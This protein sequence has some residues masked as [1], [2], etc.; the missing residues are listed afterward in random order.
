M[1]LVL[2][3]LGTA[4]SRPTLERAVPSVAVMRDGDTVLVDCGEGTQRQMLRYG[5][6]FA[7]DDV[8]FTHFHTDHFL[9]IIGLLRTLGL[10]GRTDALRL[11][12]PKGAAKWIKRAEDVGMDRL[13]FRLDVTEVQP[14][15]AIARKG[16]AWRAFAQEHRGTPCVGWALVEDTRLGRFDPD[17]ARTMGIPEG[18]LWG[19]L[20]KGETIT[21]PD[22][23]TVAPSALVGPTRA[24]RTVVLT[25]DTRPVD[26]TREIA[27]DADLL[28]HEATFGDEEA[29]RARETGHSTA[30]EAAEIAAAAGVRRLVLT[31]VSARYSRD[32]RELEREAAEVFP[33][34][35]MAKDGLEVDVPFRD[36]VPAETTPAGAL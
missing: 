18:P 14:G 3:F 23:R 4:A 36:A 11:W 6:P 5:V 22:G 33:H 19:R 7:L 30:R 8:L 9:G 26:A 28:V 12:G 17:L 1:S 24:G 16:Y 13:P 31:H 10:Q 20:H 15:D 21:L 34:V 2:R 27:R 29:E 32:A 25:G 35:V